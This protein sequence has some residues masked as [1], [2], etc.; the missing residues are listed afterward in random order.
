MTARPPNTPPPSPPPPS[1]T[2][3]DSEPPAPVPPDAPDPADASDAPGAPDPEAF[4]DAE[5]ERTLAPYR[6]VL[7]APALAELGTLLRLALDSHPVLRE[8]AARARPRAPKQASGTETVPGGE[9]GGPAEVSAAGG[10][11]RPGRS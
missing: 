5:V 8:L 11:P 6:G 3:L 10:A 2:P 7:P 1:P 4:L 9:D